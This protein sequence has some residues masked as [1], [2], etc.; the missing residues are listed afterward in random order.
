MANSLKSDRQ[1]VFC[2]EYIID[3]NGARSAVAAGYAASSARVR[4]CQ[5]LKKPYIK[6]R[7]AKEMA[8][9]SNRTYITADYVLRNIQE[10]AVEARSI[11]E[12][13]QALKGLELL[14]KHLK[15]FT[16]VSEH[17]FTVTEMGKVTVESLTGESV[18][19]EFDIGEKANEIITH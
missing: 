4:A 8:A 9:R 12:Y 18:A 16:D 7:I 19:L 3:L 2:E 15:L 17:K 10:I 13:A 6:E 14:G 11:G 5:L 1:R